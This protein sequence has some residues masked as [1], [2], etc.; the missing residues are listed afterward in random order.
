MLLLSPKNGFRYKIWMQ[1]SSSSY[2]RSIGIFIF[3]K[4]KQL[5]ASINFDLFL[6]LLLSPKNQDL[7]LILSNIDTQIL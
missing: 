4:L 6:M 7:Q 5:M 2:K 1:I 3:Y